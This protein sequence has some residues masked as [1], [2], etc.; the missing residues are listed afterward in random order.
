MMTTIPG[1]LDLAGEID[2]HTTPRLD[3]ALQSMLGT[4]GEQI[5][6]G[7]AGVTFMDSS[8][9]RVILS[10]TTQARSQGGD[11]V[12]VAPNHAVSRLIEISGLSHHLTVDVG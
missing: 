12:L 4:D 9:L 3:E 10:A 7:M 1:G 5:R 8:G 11:V 6:L 2:A